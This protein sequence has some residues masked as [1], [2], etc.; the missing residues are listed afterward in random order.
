MWELDFVEKLKSLLLERE[1]QTVS[2][3][4]TKEKVLVYV[5]GGLEL[6]IPIEAEE[7]A[8]NE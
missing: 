6:E 5:N 2:V 3:Y 4:K 1:W 8:E 7:G